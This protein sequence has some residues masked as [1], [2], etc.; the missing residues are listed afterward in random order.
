LERIEEMEETLAAEDSSAAQIPQ[1]DEIEDT[2]SAI[3]ESAFFED[4]AANTSV[5]ETEASAFLEDEAAKLPDSQTEESAF[6]EDESVKDEA[7]N[8]NESAFL[9]D[10]GANDIAAVI[11]EASPA[12]LKKDNPFIANDESAFIEDESV[13]TPQS[14]KSADEP[15]LEEVALE[16]VFDILSELENQQNVKSS[17]ESVFNEHDLNVAAA[18]KEGVA[19]EKDEELEAIVDDVIIE[20]AFVANEVSGEEKNKAAEEIPAKKPTPEAVKNEEFSAAQINELGQKTY[21]EAE[22]IKEK[23]EELIEHPVVEEEVFEELLNETFDNSFENYK[24]ELASA[25]ADNSQAV[26]ETKAVAPN[27]SQDLDEFQT[28]DLPVEIQ[29]ASGS[30]PAE[31]KKSPILQEEITE[32]A[33][34]EEVKDA[35]AEHEQSDFEVLD[36]TEQ[37]LNEDEKKAEPI[38]EKEAF[39]KMLV[40][41]DAAQLLPD[42]ILTPTFAQIY[43]EQGQPYLA[44]QIYERLL[45]QDP[46]NDT[47]AEELEKINGIVQKLQ[48]GE[49]VVIETRT[50][51]DRL[52]ANPAKKNVKSLKG[53]RIKPEIREILKEEFKKE[54]ND[55][56]NLP[57]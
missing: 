53:K 22:A 42:H 41:E 49:D 11:N 30:A 52:S 2:A 17:T 13:D 55:D 29:A 27:V 3:D 44:K 48:S 7:A 10:D 20:N 16:N 1:K 21:G 45:S 47:Y 31:A 36:N 57:E 4:E 26:C 43:L 50:Y 56:E 6:F 40:G 25:G 8:I 35:D 38:S 46:E 5:P 54:H 33:D 34:F 12:P 51:P 32:Y 9:D 37:E 39:E 23:P 18:K 19:T 14:E 24:K 28:P 15:V